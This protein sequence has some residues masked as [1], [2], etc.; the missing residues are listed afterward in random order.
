MLSKLCVLGVLMCLVCV[1]NAKKDKRY[2]VREACTS[3]S[4]HCADKSCIPGTW[5]C[6]TDE[7]CPDGS[8]EARCPTD[9]SG[10]N[11]FKCNNGNCITGVFK[12]D[13]DND[14]GDRSD[15]LNCPSG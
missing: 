5:Y 1:M 12:C 6:D 4:F 2:L 13:G 8:D 10:E 9:C 3:S 11:Q 7:D 14:C 15:E